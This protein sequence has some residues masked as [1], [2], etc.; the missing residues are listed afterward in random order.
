MKLNI[1]IPPGGYVPREL[2]P[3]LVI[4]KKI[5]NTPWGVYLK[6]IILRY[7]KLIIF[8]KQLKK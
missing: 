6:F 2:F 3:F 8:I 7:N 4:Y 5:N 1:E